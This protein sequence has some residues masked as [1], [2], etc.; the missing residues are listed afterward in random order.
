[1]LTVML[2]LNF[3]LFFAMFV[4]RE[5]ITTDYEYRVSVILQ[6][7]RFRKQRTGA[8][9]SMHSSLCTYHSLTSH[10]RLTDI[11]DVHLF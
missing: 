6:V 8:F 3:K 5:I 9:H 2:L 4:F 10:K 1:M 7:E 11:S